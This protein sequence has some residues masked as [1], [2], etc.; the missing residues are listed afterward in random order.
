[1][2]KYILTEI[3]HNTLNAGYKAKNDIR[4]VLLSEGFEAIDIKETFKFDKIPEY[5]RLLNTL[6]KLENGSEI[7]LQSPIYSFFNAKFMP[8][9]LSLLEKKEFKIILVIHDLESARFSQDADSVAREKRLLELSEKIIAHNPSMIKHI[10]ETLGI[11]QNKCI[12]LGIFDYLCDEVLR[13]REFDKSICLAGNLDAEKSGYIYRLGETDGVNLN[14]YGGNF[15]ESKASERIC[16]KGSFQP[17]D[18]PTNLIGS[19]GLVWDGSSAE[20]CVGIT[21]QYLKIN[22]PHKTSLYLASGLPIIIWSQA[23]LAPFIEKNGLGLSVDSLFELKNKL[24]LLEKE[25]YEHMLLNVKN[26]G[27][28]LRRGA[29]IK[30]AVKKAEE[31]LK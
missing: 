13:E 22:N 7:V 5:F 2:K 28:H 17:D 8:R 11:D 29:F 16:Y 30:G 31:E 25:D 19:F 9:L 15:D 24:E 20:S 14:V 1:M 27:A 4:T 21:G 3:P 12:N 18:L 26:I 23:A 10:S 6:K